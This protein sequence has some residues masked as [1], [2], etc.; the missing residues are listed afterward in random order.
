MTTGIETHTN[1]LL[2]RTEA[3]H[4][5]GTGH[6]MR[7]MALAEICTENGRQAVFAMSECPESLATRLLADGMQLVLLEDSNDIA[8]FQA[9]VKQYHPR[10][11]VFDGY[12]FGE[13]Y[14]KAI[15][16]CGRPVLTMDDGNLNHPLHADIVVNV[17]PLASSADYETIAAG[18]R[19]LLGPAYAPLRREFRHNDNLAN[20]GIAESQNILVTFGGSDPLNLTLPTVRAL[21]E[22]L[23]R[24]A[25]LDVVLGG[26]AHIDGQEIERLNH[27]HENRIRLH[28]NTPRMAE[29]MQQAS[30]AIAAAG[31][32]LWELAYLAVPTIA[33]VVADNQD[34]MLKSPLSNWFGTIDARGKRERAVDQVTAAC[35]ALWDN[36]SVREE[37][38]TM[39]KTI[40]VGAEA[41]SICKAFDEAYQGA[42]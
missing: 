10:G 6:L 8:E 39:L 25:M 19:L 3:S 16:D 28:K 24:E 35:L 11:I 37:R 9:V 41:A 18:A 22:L 20:T 23:P 33:V 26:A 7:C 21:L 17:S 32:T 5:V 34:V 30:M 42:S 36:P 4:A 13:H 29:L 40:K 2:F 27:A 1:T 31:S 12:R 38:Q 14:R 15:H